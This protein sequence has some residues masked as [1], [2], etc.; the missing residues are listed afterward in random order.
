MLLFC[1]TDL[2]TKLTRENELLREEL[3]ILKKALFGKKS[4]RIIST[5]AQLEFD[6]GVVS[7]ALENPKEESKPKAKKGRNGIK[8]N[9]FEIPEGLPCE[10]IILDVP[11]E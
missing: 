9:R 4:E 6:L 8:L 5:D 10:E 7:E 11:E 3:S 2:E 1:M